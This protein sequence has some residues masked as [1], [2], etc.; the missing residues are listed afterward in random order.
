MYYSIFSGVF[1]TLTQQKETSVKM[2][3]HE[4]VQCG[5]T[6]GD[7]TACLDCT[8]HNMETIMKEWN[9]L[10]VTITNKEITITTNKREGI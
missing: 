10:S 1:V 5:K 4:C 7:K 3:D 6:I 8:L 2:K 9:W